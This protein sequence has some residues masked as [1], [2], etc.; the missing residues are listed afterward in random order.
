MI[1]EVID[2]QQR[3]AA[4]LD[5]MEGGYRLSNTLEA[6]W[7]GKRFETLSQEEQDRISSYSFSVEIFRGISDPQVLQIFSRL[8]TYSV[9]LNAQELRNGQFFG[10]FKQTAYSLAYEHLEFW[11]RNRVFSEQAIARMLEAEFVSELLIAFLAGMQDKKKSINDFYEKYDDEFK[12]QTVMDKRFREVVDEVNEAFTDGL[13]DTAFKRPH[14]LYT[15]FCAVYHHRHGLPETTL[16]TPKRGLSR[17]E[18]V[19][20]RDAVEFLSEKIEAAR[21]DEDVSDRYQAFV[22]AS[23]RGQTDNIKPRQ[24]RLSNLYRKA[25]E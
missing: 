4:V 25:F 3:I 8:N 14:L 10:L 7:A 23:I 20:L 16:A 19:S 11:R 21:N 13:Q 24:V 5:F 22:E 2:G 15:L 17:D 12:Q 18:R 9:P 1:R 6:D